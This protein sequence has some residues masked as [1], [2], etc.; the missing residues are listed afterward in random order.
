MNFRLLNHLEIKPS[1]TL[2]LLVKCKLKTDTLDIF[3]E[4]MLV[5]KYVGTCFDTIF[6]GYNVLCNSLLFLQLNCTVISCK[7]CM[8]TFFCYVIQVRP[9]ALH[10]PH[11]QRLASSYPYIFLVIIFIYNLSPYTYISIILNIY[12]YIQNCICYFVYKE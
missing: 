11:A 6:S 3:S 2:A 1:L 12:I 10:A 9:R 7:H 8:H 5:K 4:C